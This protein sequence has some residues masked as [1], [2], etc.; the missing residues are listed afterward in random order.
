M[1]DCS[2]SIVDEKAVGQTGGFADIASEKARAQGMLIRTASIE[3]PT[4]PYIRA[5]ELFCQAGVYV[6]AHDDIC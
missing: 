5:L 4:L 6:T 2:H 3:R 1:M